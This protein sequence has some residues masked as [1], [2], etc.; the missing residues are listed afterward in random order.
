MCECGFVCMCV[1]VSVCFGSWNV[2]NNISYLSCPYKLEETYNRLK[3]IYHVLTGLWF[4]VF[5]LFL[6]KNEQG[7]QRPQKLR[8]LKSTKIQPHP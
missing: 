4:P 8:S 3:Y 5:V 2:E 6:S 1:C 7:P